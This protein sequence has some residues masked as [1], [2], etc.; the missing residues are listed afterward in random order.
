[1]WTKYQKFFKNNFFTLVILLAVITVVILCY[2]RF[3][4]RHDYIIGYE[5]ECDPAIQSCFIG[6]EDDTCTEEYYYAKAQKY[7]P[8]LLSE[9]GKDITDCEF[10]NMCLENDRFCSIIY[11]D[12]ILDGDD[13]CSKNDGDMDNSLEEFNFNNTNI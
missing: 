11:C 5:S 8:D 13:M 6:C 12:L 1:M 2:N 10:A 3:I 9:C 4:V 7:A